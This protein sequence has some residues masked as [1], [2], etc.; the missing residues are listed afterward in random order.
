MG[1]GLREGGPGNSRISGK[2][3]AFLSYYCNENEP[4]VDI[5]WI[6]WSS[7]VPLLAE[8]VLVE[9]KTEASFI[10]QSLKPDVD[11]DCCWG[12]TS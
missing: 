8:V 12:V 10:I 11:V 2:L 4:F 5:F 1:L 6:V 9:K 7:G 3:W